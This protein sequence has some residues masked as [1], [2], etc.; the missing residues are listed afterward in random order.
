[1]ICP[2][3]GNF[4][5]AMSALTHTDIDG[6]NMADVLRTR[7]S[8]G[9]PTLFICVG[10]QILARSSEESPGVQGMTYIHTY[11]HG[12]TYIHIYIHIP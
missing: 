6:Q 1:M 11:I 10:M 7:V 4:G 5:A 9:K 2:G 3:V 8:D 12:H